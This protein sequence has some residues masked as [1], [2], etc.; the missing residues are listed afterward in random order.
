M[1]IG[2]GASR[3]VCLTIDE[4]RR[5]G[6]QKQRWLENM[7]GEIWIMQEKG[8]LPTEPAPFLRLT[9][10]T[11]AKSTHRSGG[12]MAHVKALVGAQREPDTEEADKQHR[13]GLGLRHGR[14]RQ[15]VSP[16]PPQ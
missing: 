2:I 11:S 1:V 7:P 9:R 12:D 3:M 13:P 8:G 10:Q 6:N 14:Y 16:R 15:R 5:P 4:K